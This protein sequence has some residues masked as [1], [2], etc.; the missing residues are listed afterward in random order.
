MD[1]IIGKKETVVSFA[2]GGQ[3]YNH[4]AELEGQWRVDD[5]NPQDK[6]GT[7]NVYV[8]YPAHNIEAVFELTEVMRE[9]PHN[10]GVILE[11]T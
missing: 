11:C 2:Q 6:Y 3:F 10:G 9:F 5:V 7:P 4:G 1:Y 8:T